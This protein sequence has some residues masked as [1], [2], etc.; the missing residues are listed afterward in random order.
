M[1]WRGVMHRRTA[2]QREGGGELHGDLIVL[3][4]DVRLASFH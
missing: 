3:P 4:V 2:A 1:G